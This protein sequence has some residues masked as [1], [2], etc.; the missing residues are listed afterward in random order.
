MAT[1]RTCGTCEHEVFDEE[2]TGLC[3][4]PNPERYPD[5]WTPRKEDDDAEQ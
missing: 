4:K 2:G 3:V 1:D 5:C